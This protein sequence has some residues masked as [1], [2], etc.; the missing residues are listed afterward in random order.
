MQIRDLIV[1]RVLPVVAVFLAGVIVLVVTGGGTVGI[2]IGLTLTGGALVLAIAF[3]FLE[4]G[5]S[6]DRERAAEE[7]RRKRRPR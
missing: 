5:L 2:T 3:V 7:A 4:V 6:E 1:R